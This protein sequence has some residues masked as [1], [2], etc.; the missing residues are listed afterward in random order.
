MKYDAE[1]VTSKFCEF[2][3]TVGERFANSI[4]PPK[5]SINEYLSKMSSSSTTLFLS[6]TN[7]IEINNLIQ[8]LLNK[9]SSGHD[10]YPA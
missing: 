7:T 9:N 8:N 2:F 3:S 5:L 4:A 1:S 6:P 10:S